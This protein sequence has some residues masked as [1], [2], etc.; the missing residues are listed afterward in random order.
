MASLAPALQTPA[1][2]GEVRLNPRDAA[3]APLIEFNFLADE[4]D[5]VRLTEALRLATDLF[6]SPAMQEICGAPFILTDA[7]RLMRYNAVSRKNA[8]LTQLAATGLDLN[9]RFGV[10]LLTRLARLQAPT[11]LLAQPESLANFVKEQVTGTGHVCG[12]C[13]MGTS[14]D[15][16][17]VCDADG[18]VHRIGGLRVADASVMPTVPSGNTHLPTVMVAEK[19]AESICK[20]SSR[21]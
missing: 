3:A 21:S 4:R 19:L 20:E 8:F 16:D 11:A 13:R 10:A 15:P 2:R 6:E 18:R 14:A 17:A 1:S 9:E 7:T 12:T 5:L